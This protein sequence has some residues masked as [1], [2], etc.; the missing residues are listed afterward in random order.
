MMGKKN[1]GNCQ[2]TKYK[3]RIKLTPLKLHIL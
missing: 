3:M 2:I 1:L